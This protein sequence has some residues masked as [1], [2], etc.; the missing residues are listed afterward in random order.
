MT[1]R[2]HTGGLY[3]TNYVTSEGNWLHQILFRCFIAKEVNTFTHNT[4]PFLIIC[5][6]NYYF[7]FHLTSPIWTILCMSITRNPNKNQLK[8]QLVMQQKRKNAKR[9][10]YFCKA[11]KSLVQPLLSSKTLWEKEDVLLISVFGFL[12]APGLSL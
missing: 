7:F 6:F 9:D 11:L 1:L 2:L 5:I 12:G 8:L 10:E 4:F 3:L